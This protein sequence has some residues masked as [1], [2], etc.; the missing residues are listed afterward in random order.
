MS[1]QHQNKNQNAPHGSTG[2]VTNTVA[3]AVTVSVLGALSY[4]TSTA[5]SRYFP[6]ERER[7]PSESDFPTVPV[8]IARSILRPP[9][10]LVSYASESMPNYDSTSGQ[11]C[12]EDSSNQDLHNLLNFTSDKITKEDL[13]L[14]SNICQR[15]IRTYLEEGDMKKV[16]QLAK[17]NE[18][19]VET[20]NLR[21]ESSQAILD[22]FDTSTYPT[23]LSEKERQIRQC[24]KELADLFP[25]MVSQDQSI[26][27]NKSK[28]ERNAGFF[29]R[30]TRAIMGPDE[31][32]SLSDLRSFEDERILRSKSSSAGTVS[33]KAVASLKICD[34]KQSTG[35]KRTL[36]SDTCSVSTVAK[37][38]KIMPED[39]NQ[40][41]DDVSAFKKSPTGRRLCSVD[42]CY[43]TSDGNRSN[44][45]CRS[46]YNESKRKVTEEGNLVE[47]GDPE[48]EED[49]LAESQDMSALTV[50]D[51]CADEFALT[52]RR[53]SKVDNLFDSS[54]G[55][56]S[57]E[58]ADIV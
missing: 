49:L 23:K 14:F 11:C 31:K 10:D 28:A 20:R 4:A 27:V 46:H 34:S 50:E 1:N 58:D 2:S 24:Q 29:G 51:S 30:V 45:M 41:Q 57:D 18:V 37:K 3:T 38:A 36:G 56:S 25:D 43:K 32:K 40:S 6:E 52:G 21:L 5:L 42:G 35:D 44:Q 47:P 9:I 55:D 12:D 48:V 39:C 19:V 22:G 54:D 33:K 53:E 7:T 26:V 16:G 17:M 15:M 8:A 13:E